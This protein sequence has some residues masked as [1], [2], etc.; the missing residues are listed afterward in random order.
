MVYLVEADKNFRIIDNVSVEL[1]NLY[2]DMPM[3]I[4]LRQA[5]PIPLQLEKI[6]VLV[7]VRN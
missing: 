7:N 5:Q 4:I 6:Y 2:L 3:E 1:S